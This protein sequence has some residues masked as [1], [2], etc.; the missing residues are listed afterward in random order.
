M[1]RFPPCLGA[2]V[3]MTKDGVIGLNKQL[4]WHYSEDLR[5][6]KR[7]T[8]NSCIIMGRLTWE[9]IG[10]KALPGRRNIVVSRSGVEGVEGYH[11]IEEALSSCIN[12]Q[13]WII[14]GGQIYRSAVDYLTVLDITYVPDTV[15]DK[16][17][18]HFPD[19]DNQV[20]QAS[21]PNRLGDTEL[22]NTIYTRRAEHPPSS[23]I[24]SL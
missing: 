15:N 11:S 16:N 2:I 17:A 20:W 13:V 22:V 18:I 4:P 24:T 8:L 6:F 9:S 14:G 5:R 3:A 19:I 1:D 7:I 10:S 12:E 21:E 23:L